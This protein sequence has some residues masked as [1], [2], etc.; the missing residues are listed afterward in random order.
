MAGTV[1][2]IRSAGDLFAGSGLLKQ[3]HT[4]YVSPARPATPAPVFH[5]HLNLPSVHTTFPC[6]EAGLRKRPAPRGSSRPSTE[7]IREKSDIVYP[8]LQKAQVVH[9]VPCSRTQ[10]RTPTHSC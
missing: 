9:V 3:L 7:Q 2:S 6:R 1:A 4:R 8:L 10:R 5:K